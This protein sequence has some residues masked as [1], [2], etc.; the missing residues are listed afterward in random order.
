MTSVTVLKKT[1]WAATFPAPNVALRNVVPSVA[2]NAGGFM[3]K[4]KWREPA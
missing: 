4:S 1:V 3:S 2:V